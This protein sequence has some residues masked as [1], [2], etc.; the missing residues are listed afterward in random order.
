MKTSHGAHSTGLLE[1]F[2]E[3]FQDP[4]VS[5]ILIN[6]PNEVWVENKVPWHVIHA[7]LIAIISAA[8]FV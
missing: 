7:I 2:K 6:L 8:C 5:E 1:P 4:L 3:W